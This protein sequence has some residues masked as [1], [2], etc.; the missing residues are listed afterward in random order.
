MTKRINW[1]CPCGAHN[2]FMPESHNQTMF[3]DTCTSCGL[4]STIQPDGTIDDPI[5]CSDI[6]ED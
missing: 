3:K 4:H 1:C 2:L 6:E 5:E